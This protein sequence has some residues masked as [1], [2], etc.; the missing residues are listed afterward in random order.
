MIKKGI[1]ELTEADI[2]KLDAKY[3]FKTEYVSDEEEAYLTNQL[4]LKQVTI[5]LQP[6]MIDFYKREA[7]S[8]GLAYQAYMRQILSKH[9]SKLKSKAKS[10]LP[11]TAP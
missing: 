3:P 11:E 7:A 10:R 1:P 6:D 4:T 2:N 9:M 8:Q 5:R